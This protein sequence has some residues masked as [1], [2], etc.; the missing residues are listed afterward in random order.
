MKRLI[1]YWCYSLLSFLLFAIIFFSV[2]L[3]LRLLNIKYYTPISVIWIIVFLFIYRASKIDVFNK[4]MRVIYNSMSK[5][6]RVFDFYVYISI[7]V[8]MLIYSLLNWEWYITLAI[9][10]GI[11]LSFKT[12]MKRV[13]GGYPDEN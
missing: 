2:P 10:L 7:F 9:V 12:L 8:A 6:Q 1:K 4:R 11:I 13:E 5:G 3:T